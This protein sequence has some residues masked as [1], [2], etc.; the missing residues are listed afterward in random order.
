MG[1][2]LEEL[3]FKWLYSQVASV[4]LKNPAQTYWSLL[5]QLHKKEFDWFVPNDDNRQEDGR[6]LRY[7]FAD[8]TNTPLDQAWLDLGC[9]F[10]EMLIGLSRRLTFESEGTAREW[11]WQLMINLDLD[12]YNDAHIHRREKEIDN[13]ME[14]VIRR[15]YHP[16]GHGGLFP[17]QTPSEDQRY[18]ELWYQLSEYLLERE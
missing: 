17:L 15:T 11:F 6:D 13:T 7:E 3:Y 16:D 1:E 8:K 5:K 12:L 10:L 4:R 9:S 18:V 14:R 2:P